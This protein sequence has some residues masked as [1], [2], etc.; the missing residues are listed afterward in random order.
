MRFDRTAPILKKASFAEFVTTEWNRDDEEEPPQHAL[1]PLALQSLAALRDVSNTLL[2]TLHRLGPS[3]PDQQNLWQWNSPADGVLEAQLAHTPRPRDAL[4][5]KKPDPI[6]LA[7][8]PQDALTGICAPYADLHYHI[9]VRTGASLR[10]ARLQKCRFEFGEF[11]SVEFFHAQLQGIDFGRAHLQRAQFGS[12]QLEGAFLVEAQ[13][14]RANFSK[15]Q[16]QFVDLVRAELLGANLSQTQIRLAD[17]RGG[18]LY[19]VNRF[20][21]GLQRADLSEANSRGH[22]FG[23]P[24]FKA[25]NFVVLP[26]E[27]RKLWSTPSSPQITRM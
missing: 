19:G 5:E 12:S 25:L 4:A 6:D 13:L 3:G 18:R 9:R 24:S 11:P 16:M 1:P 21:T 2:Q 23:R 15:T 26:S 27:L 7:F 17:I 20:Q 22:I 14:Q 8:L 10:G